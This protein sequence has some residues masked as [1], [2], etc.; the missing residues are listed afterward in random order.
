[1]TGRISLSGIPELNLAAK[2]S[3]MTD[4][5]YDSY[6][7]ELNS[8]I[9][10]LPTQAKKMRESLSQKKFSDVS[11]QLLSLCSI[12]EKIHANELANGFRKVING[13][14]PEDDSKLSKFTEKFILDVSSLS[15]QIQT[16]AHK[17]RQSAPAR[18]APRTVKKFSRASILAVDNAVMF[19][20]SLKRYLEDAPYDL[21]CVSSGRD[22]LKYLDSNK[23]DLFLL[24][25]EMPEMD[26]FELARKIKMR[27]IK[28]P[29]IF[30]TANSDREDVD[31]AF[32][33]GAVD[34]LIKPFRVN[35]LLEKIKAYT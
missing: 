6:L 25:I 16:A 3:K 33:V 34:M 28:A 9:D 24:D 23:P 12:L 22:A 29:I 30:V 27:D 13:F 14:R 32:K 1:M 4:A 15:L 5:Q 26:G 19:L 11:K 21:H 31:M 17:S 10:N 20:N 8:F 2:I 35:Q 7:K 18:A